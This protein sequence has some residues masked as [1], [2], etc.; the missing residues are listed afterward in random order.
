MIN[1]YRKYLDK[2]G[3]NSF[4]KKAKQY[5]YN[6]TDKIVFSLQN[7]K[8]FNTR[9]SMSLRILGLV[10]NLGNDNLKL[11]TAGRAFLRFDNKQEI[12]DEQ[13]LKMYLDSDINFRLSIKI[14]PLRVIYSIFTQ[15]SYIT[16][17]EYKIF[18]CWI[19]NNSEIAN[20]VYFIKWY[21][22]SDELE[23][24]EMVKIFNSKILEL[25][26][27]NFDDDIYRLF[28]MFALSSYIRVEGSRFNEIIY[29]NSKPDIY[30][31]IINSLGRIRIDK[32]IYDLTHYKKIIT[33]KADYDYILNPLHDLSNEER[34]IL[35]KQINEKKSLPDIRDIIPSFISP[36]IIER[37][38]RV[39]RPQNR[40]KKKVDYGARDTRNR[41]VGLHAEKIVCKYEYNRLVKIG[42]NDLAQEIVHESLSND[43]LGYDITSYDVVADNKEKVLVKH[44]EVKAI[45]GLPSTFSFFISKNE[46]EKVKND[47]AHKIY[48]VFNYETKK[49]KIWQLPHLFSEQK[50]IEISPVKFIVTLT[51]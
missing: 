50:L 32:Y 7:L 29:R 19:N 9:N 46:L 5:E 35:F 22:K 17:E 6:T 27:Q 3:S 18:I 36:K 16:F 40:S 42:R 11:T 10:E 43:S 51:I 25:G 13:L 8:Q 33:Q 15:L 20:V 12:I 31:N 2:K 41:L 47:P 21:R 44:I 37:K 24:V 30:K 1:E 34:S 26:I 4:W 39:T 28:M 45:N 38:S 48:I 49:P 23:K 14:F